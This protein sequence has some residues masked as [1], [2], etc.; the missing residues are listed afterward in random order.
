VSEFPLSKAPDGL[1]GSLDLKTLGRNPQSV[2]DVLSPSIE[3]LDYYLLRNRLA[4]SGGA[5]FVSVNTPIVLTSAVAGIAQYF[6]GGAFVVPAQETLRLKNIAVHVQ[7]AAADVGLTLEMD[8]FIRRVTGVG[9][10]V[11]LGSTIHGA[12]PATDLFTS[13]QLPLNDFLWLGPGDALIVIPRTTQ[14]AAGSN[15]VLH[16]DLDSVPSG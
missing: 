9:A 1:L 16:L 5:A 2:S 8:V 13:Q 6:S 4:I 11:L 15:V 3:T 14:T 10:T 7:R 12:R